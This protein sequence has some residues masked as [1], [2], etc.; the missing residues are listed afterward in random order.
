MWLSRIS[1]TPRSSMRLRWQKRQM[2]QISE[3]DLLQLELNKLN[4]QS[5][6]TDSE[7]VEKQYVSAAFIPRP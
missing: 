5:T 2:G 3:N 6:L 7:L 4:A 1:P